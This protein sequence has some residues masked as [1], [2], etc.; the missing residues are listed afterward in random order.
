MM[1]FQA[2]V[3]R[4][5]VVGGIDPFFANVTSLLHM[6]GANGGTI[7]TDQKG[8]TWATAVSVTSTAQA[9]FGLS[10]MDVNAG[11]IYGTNALSASGFGTGDFTVE[12]WFY[13]TSTA[14][15]GLFD[16]ALASSAASLAAG[17][18]QGSGMWQVYFNGTVYT[19]SAT[20]TTNS[21]VHFALVRNG[22]TVDLYINGVSVLTA[23][24]AAN[25]TFTDLHIGRYY[26][27][28]FPWVGY[29]DEFRVTKGVARYTANFT[30]PTAAFLDS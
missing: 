26:N 5:P 24:N 4:N 1:P 25:L 11:G 20:L 19:G 29:I 16:A 27:T 8:L 23:T 3:L 30:P 10:S 6:E 28:S 18:D 14:T 12:G 22:S 17:W 2:M 7:F 13:A 9:K 15:R 21:W